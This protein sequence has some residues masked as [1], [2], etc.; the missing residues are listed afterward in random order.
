MLIHVLY[1]PL[2]DMM[3]GHQHFSYSPIEYDRNP[4]PPVPPLY[5]RQSPGLPS[6][7]SSMRRLPPLSI[8]PSREEIWT[9]DHNHIP[10]FPPSFSLQPM[11]DAGMQSPNSYPGT[12]DASY[13]LHPSSPYQPLHPPSLETRHMNHPMHFPGEGHPPPP[14]RNA[15]PAEW[16]SSSA[17]ADSHLVSPYARRDMMGHSP[18]EPSPVD[19]PQVKKKRKRADAQQLKI[20]NEVYART[21][22]PTT[23]ERLEL[24]RKLDM[25]ARSVQIWCVFP[26]FGVVNFSRVIILSVCCFALTG[27]RIN[28]N[29]LDKVVLGRELF[30]RLYITLTR[31]NRLKPNHPHPLH[32]QELALRPDP[33]S[34]SVGMCRWGPVLRGVAP[35]GPYIMHHLGLHIPMF[36]AEN[37][38]PK[39]TVSVLDDHPTNQLL[40]IISNL[41]VWYTPHSSRLFCQS[42]FFLFRFHSLT[43][44]LALYHI[45]G[46]S[47]PFLIPYV[48]NEPDSR[49]HLS[50]NHSPSLYRCPAFLCI[51]YFL[52][53]MYNYAILDTKPCFLS[54]FL[55]TYISHSIGHT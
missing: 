50:I 47:L 11:P 29:L 9:T 1:Y 6:D 43:F 52:V 26:G 54:L 30:P 46:G 37:V 32:P 20:L 34:R 13:H 41:C 39:R 25:S 15:H 45:V 44:C 53:I 51:V 55:F 27:S 18:Q 16:P 31:P 40:E 33:K 3:A 14:H 35:K 2:I 28:D 21:A 38:V 24:A 19:Y 48:H 49:N 42:F 4:S 8:P 17:R 23:E 36:V 22:F 12:Y 7:P 10:G 5:Q